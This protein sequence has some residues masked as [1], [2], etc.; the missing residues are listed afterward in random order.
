ML[1]AVV[2]TCN[3]IL[4]EDGELLSSLGSIE[5]PCLKNQTKET[6]KHSGSL[7]KPVY[8]RGRDR[9]D[10]GLRPV[11]AESSQDPIS[12]NKSWA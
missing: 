9:E 1:G 5:I 6:T 4:Q 11:K 10:R 2:H 8:L 3:P 12:I 7:C